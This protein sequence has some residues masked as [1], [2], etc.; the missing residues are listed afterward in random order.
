[1]LV[2]KATNQFKKPINNKQISYNNIYG[3]EKLYEAYKHLQSDP[4]SE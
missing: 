3:Y 2:Q 1:M 4:K